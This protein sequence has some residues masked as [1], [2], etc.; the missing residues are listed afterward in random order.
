VAAIILLTPISNLPPT[1][2]ATQILR[3]FAPARLDGAITDLVP[4]A[5]IEVL[6]DG[7][8]QKDRDAVALYLTSGVQDVVLVDPRLRT[9]E[10]HRMNQASQTHQLPAA[11]TLTMGCLLEID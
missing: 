2:Y 10:W 5:V 3:S 8:E 1:C 6:S 11:C 7:Y 9:M 4:G